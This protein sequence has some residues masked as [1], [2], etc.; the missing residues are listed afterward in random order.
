MAQKFVNSCI[1][2][3]SIKLSKLQRNIFVWKEHLI[4]LE[5]TGMDDS[6]YFLQ[7][8]PPNLFQQLFF[9]LLSTPQLFYIIP[10]KGY[11]LIRITNGLHRDSAAYSQGFHPVFSVSHQP[12]SVFSCSEWKASGGSWLEVLIAPVRQTYMGCDNFMAKCLKRRSKC[13][14]KIRAYFSIGSFQYC[15]DFSI[16]GMV[17]VDTF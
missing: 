15:L 9:F 17:P 10:G 3:S 7:T 6:D 5:S 13:H 4:F 8:I 14:S 11:S 1:L 12:W 16:F 2:C